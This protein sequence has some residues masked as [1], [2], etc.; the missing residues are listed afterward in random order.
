MSSR[1]QLVACWVAVTN[2]GGAVG[3]PWPPVTVED[4]M[5]AV[6]QL[7]RDLDDDRVRLIVADDAEGVAGWVGLRRN[8]SP[9][10]EHWASVR[11]LQTHPCTRNLGIGTQLMRAVARHARRSWASRLCTWS[12]AAGWGWRA[13]TSGWGGRSSGAGP[14]PCGSRRTTGQGR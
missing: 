11:R 8:T 9:L 7:A 12:C 5:P 3:F 13:S 10:V 1:A 6:A 14:T 2:A 4:L